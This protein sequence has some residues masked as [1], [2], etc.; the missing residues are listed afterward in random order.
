MFLASSAWA[1]RIGGRAS[2][3]RGKSTNLIFL[4]R[5]GVIRG[6]GG[7]AG[8]TSRIRGRDLRGAAGVSAA[9]LRSNLLFANT[10]IA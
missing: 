10:L 6:A 1:C 4:I 9:G 2:T 7:G 3:S 8:S 5:F